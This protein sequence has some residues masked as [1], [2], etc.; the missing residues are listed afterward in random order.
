MINLP[1]GA[2]KENLHLHYD[3]YHHHHPPTTL[4]KR[5]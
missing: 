1:R 2:K 3:Y 4:K 5:H